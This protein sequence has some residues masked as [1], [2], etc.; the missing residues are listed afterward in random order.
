MNSTN[1][2]LAEQRLTELIQQFRL[3]TSQPGMN[4]EEVNQI[5][6][7]IFE[8]IAV[9]LRTAIKPML[10]K[11]FGKGVYST[12]ED[13]SVRFSVMLNDLFVKILDKERG[14]A[15]RVETAKHLRNWCSRV[16]VNQMIDLIRK[17]KAREQTLHDLSGLYEI[18]KSAF[19]RRFGET[20]DDFLEIISDW[21]RHP[22]PRLREYAWLLEL[23]YVMGMSWREVCDVMA[24]PKS[25]FFETRRRAIDSVKRL[26]NPDDPVPTA[27]EEESTLS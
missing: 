20:F 27:D 24:M 19:S 22:N 14:A 8:L 25:T 13:S 16:I 9:Y 3:A 21:Y 12:R 15:L 5:E 26:L 6:S 7:Q 4:A 1:E 18:R 11:T 10:A 23:H 17:R 2:D